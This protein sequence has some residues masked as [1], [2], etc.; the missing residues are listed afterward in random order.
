MALRL[1]HMLVD[2]EN[3]DDC[4]TAMKALSKHDA[5]KVWEHI[6]VELLNRPD[7]GTLPSGQWFGIQ[8]DK[9]KMLFDML[10]R[11]AFNE[12]NIVCVQRVV[13]EIVGAAD[14]RA[15]ERHLKQLEEMRAANSNAI[16]EL[17][18][19]YKKLLEEKGLECEE[20][21][22]QTA[23]ELKEEYEKQ[24]LNKEKEHAENLKD[25]LEKARYSYE[26]GI[27]ESY[28]EQIKF[29]E[30]KCSDAKA[31]VEQI[32]REFEQGIEAEQEKKKKLEEEI[33]RLKIE[34]S[35]VQNT[36][37]IMDDEIIRVIDSDMN[38]TDLRR[39]LDDMLAPLFIK[40]PTWKTLNWFSVQN[41]YFYISI[42][43]INKLITNKES[44]QVGRGT[45]KNVKDAIKKLFELR[46]L[47]IYRHEIPYS[48]LHSI[49][50]FWLRSNLGDKK[51][52]YLALHPDP[53]GN[54]QYNNNP[55]WSVTQSQNTL[56][57]QSEMQS[58][59]PDSWFKSFDL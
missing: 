44:E 56:L 19:K 29:W 48:L 34:A 53:N 25:E 50:T 32:K 23:E 33:E 3:W 49:I 9:Y 5:I 57:F 47:A 26:T 17:V 8:T 30:K 11:E 40:Y 4:V 22:K 55:K 46:D 35:K 31:E 43:A 37:L 21:A 10:L 6:V 13:G 28:E 36:D 52:N 27:K 18:A 59:S 1:A 12:A 39:T 24:L 54:I 42:E 16:D 7:D 15:E 2:G 58:S 14:E 51:K 45:T 38:N 20:V 41:E